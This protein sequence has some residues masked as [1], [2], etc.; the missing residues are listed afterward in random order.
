[1]IKAATDKCNGYKPKDDNEAD[2]ILIGLWAYETYGDA[3][4]LSNEIK[5]LK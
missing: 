4:S 3:C 2:A 1:M 5:E